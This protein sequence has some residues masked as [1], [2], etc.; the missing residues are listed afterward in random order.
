MNVSTIRETPILIAKYSSLNGCNYR[1]IFIGELKAA[2]IGTVFQAEGACCG[3][4]VTDISFKVV[5]KDGTGC[6]VVQH[7]EGTTDSDNPKEYVVND[8]L[9]WIQFGN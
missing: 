9:L 8:E 7:E 5:Y 2:K 6:A 1:E 4:D 3:R